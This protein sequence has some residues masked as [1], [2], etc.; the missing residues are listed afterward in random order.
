[1]LAS[2]EARGWCRVDLA[3][4]TLDIW[5]LGLFQPSQTVN[6]AVDVAVRVGVQTR[7]AGYV[8][9]QGD[10]THEATTISDLLQD[11]ETA[12]VGQVL[13]ALDTAPVEV[14]V[15]SDSPRGGGLG[16]SSALAVTLISALERLSGG[17]PS[18]PS[19]IVQL[20][21][22][23]EARMMRLPT[24]TQDHFPALLGGCLAIEH[25]PGGAH[26][27][28]L[29]V[30]LDS[31]G[32]HLAVAYSGMS[33]FSAANNWE[34]VRSALNGDAATVQRF[35]TI[36]GIAARMATSLE[37]GDFEAAGRLLGEEWA[38][39]RRLA[40]TVSNPTLDRLMSL[41]A[42]AGAWGGK[43]CGAGGG[44]CV[45]ILA[46]SDRLETVREAL[47]QG[48]ARPIE[49]RPIGTGIEITTSN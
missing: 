19:E 3:G 24:G 29:A 25:R 43:A 17:S 9:I 23:L 14:R 40:E 27:R 49:C 10:E 20:A 34:V 44:G 13:E 7:S 22:D 11:P 1:M 38:A 39:R 6:V 4:G 30:D 46:P 31:L 32:N 37:A 8:V 47:V 26:P 21:R 12:L 33:H 42:A 45:A 41:A 18:A 5:P 28:R 2:V 35:E 48:G 36:A 15:D 16:A